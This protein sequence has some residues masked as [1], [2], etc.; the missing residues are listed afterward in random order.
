[1]RASSTRVNV[2]EELKLPYIWAIRSNH[3]LWLPQDKEVYQE[4]WQR[5]ER[6]IS[7]G[8]T[9]IRYMAEVIYGQRHRQQDWLPPKPCQTIQLRLSWSQ[10]RR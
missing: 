7:K 9:E 8:T 2:L 1:M 5:F 10:L 3:A 4:P 6:T